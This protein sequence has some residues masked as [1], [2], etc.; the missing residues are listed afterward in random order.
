M[1]LSCTSGSPGAL[2]TRVENQALFPLKRRG[3]GL[4]SFFHH[5][6]LACA[7]IRTVAYSLDCTPG[8]C[9][10]YVLE[11]VVQERCVLCFLFG[12]V[13]KTWNKARLLAA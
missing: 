3:Q 2:A 11:A 13:R 6:C 7:W 1:F 12:S 8:V 4:V 9:S 10:V 5:D